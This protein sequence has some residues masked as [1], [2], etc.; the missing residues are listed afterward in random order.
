MPAL[1]EAKLKNE[2]NLAAELRQREA[3][4]ERGIKNFVEVGRALDQV[5]EGKLYLACRLHDGTTPK[6]FEEYLMGRWGM[7]MSQGYRLIDA[8][9]VISN[10][11]PIGEIMRTEG[12]ARELVGLSALTQQLA[13]QAALQAQIDSGRAAQPT[14]E[15][16]RQAVEW[17]AIHFREQIPEKDFTAIVNKTQRRIKAEDKAMTRLEYLDLAIKYVD[18]ALKQLAQEW[19]HL[20]EIVSQT[21]ARLRA[22][23][24]VEKKAKR[25]KG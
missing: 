12:Q 20:E 22:E 21:L 2:L 3:I 14:A 8:A 6:T 24:P 25:K 5:R 10:L 11:S 18:K 13:W 7:G 23:K 1:S 4:I 9:K 15:E 17:V 16:I 19:P